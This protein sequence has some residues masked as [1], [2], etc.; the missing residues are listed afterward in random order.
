MQSKVICSQKLSVNISKNKV[1]A[2]AFRI[3]FLC[4]PPGLLGWFPPPPPPIVYPPFPPE[5]A[6]VA[7]LSIWEISC[8]KENLILIT[9][10]ILAKLSENLG[11]LPRAS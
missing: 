6:I 8:Q 5:R 3:F 11:M 9:E 7:A 2:Y 4:F 10:L 1:L